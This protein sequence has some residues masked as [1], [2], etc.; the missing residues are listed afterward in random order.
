MTKNKMLDQWVKI[1]KMSALAIVFAIMV[2]FANAGADPNDGTE[3]QDLDYTESTEMIK[4][5]H[6]GYPENQNITHAVHLMDTGNVAENDSGF[7]WYYINLNQFSAGN[8]LYDP[9]ERD[10]TS[11]EIVY[12]NGNPKL[13]TEPFGGTDKPISSDALAALSQ[14][15]GNL[16]TSG[17]SAILRFVYDWNGIAGCEPS[18]LSWIIT[19]IEQLCEV[20][21][22]YPDVV[23]GFECGIIGVFG[24]M[25]TSIYTGKANANQ[26]IDAYLDN[27][28]E[29][30]TLMLRSSAYMADYFEMSREQLS[31]V[32]TV[33]G[34]NG[35]RLSYYN[36][37]YMNSGNDL[38]TWEN[39]NQDIDFLASQSE[40]APYGGEYGSAYWDLPHKTCLPENAVQEMY[41]THVS[42][43]RSNVYKVGDV[44]ANGYVSKFG[45]DLFTYAAQYEEE[46]FPDNSAFYGYDC[47]TFITAHLGY[48]LVL[49]ESR[50]SSSASAGGIMKLKGVIE[51]TGFANV[52]HEPEAY[53]LLTNESG[54]VHIFDNIDPDAYAD[55][56]SCQK[57][58]Y[59]FTLSLPDS[60][61]EGE[62]DV[63]LRLSGINIS[64]ETSVKSGIR[65][66]N[67][68]IK[69]DPGSNTY[70]G[71]IYDPELG[72]NK[73]G[74]ITVEQ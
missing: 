54:I 62:Y 52:L 73:L 14:T 43:I 37:G 69:Y 44:A 63:Y 61:E 38:G 3:E 16:R 19:H 6:M 70:G 17:G 36:D 4:N 28:P 46:W 74:R 2:S 12:E 42:F 39:R 18:N 58:A 53:I 29:S 56:K 33:K 11:G 26:I 49:R 20:V 72:A 15:L 48:R 7:C 66:A 24:E 27:T 22:D 55:L 8:S 30:M 51:N 50:I 45:Y 31:E 65:F 34:S 32:V 35:Y 23:S 67:S 5:P 71:G 47:H 64:A 25:H 10:E 60:L 9:Y 1:C 40:H 41:R 68:G 21:S 59:S 57:H 13:R